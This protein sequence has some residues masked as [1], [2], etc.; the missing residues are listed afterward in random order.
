M[1]L[2]HLRYF[3]AVAEELNFTR[4][5][6]RVGIGQPPLSLQIRA[7]EQEIGA[8]L[9]RRVPHGAELTEAGVVFLEYA[10]SML[11]EAERAGEAARRAARGETGRLRVGFT[12]SAAFHPIVAATIREFRRAYPQVGLP[13]QEANTAQALQRLAAG[14]LDA[15]FIRP[16]ITDPAGMRLRRLVEEPMRIVLPAG[17]RLAERPRLPLSELSGEAFVLFPR[18][19]GLALYDEILTACRLAGFEPALGQEA[20]QI[21]S[22]VNLVA[23]E[24]GV[25]IVPASIAQMQVRGVRYVDIDGR[26]PLA[27]LALA[28]RQ[29]EHSSAVDNLFSKAVSNMTYIGMQLLM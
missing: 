4:A 12:G 18:A 2:R 19:V 13:L 10:R 15:A 7:L 27:R 6:A 9:F 24:L 3:V 26:P 16:G 29:G 11:N 23:A 20:S 21:S 5:A 1:E 22:V 25:S 8:A 14:E 28:C 17:H